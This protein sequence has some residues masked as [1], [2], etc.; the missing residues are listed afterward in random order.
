MTTAESSDRLATALAAA[1]I[2]RERCGRARTE[3]LSRGEGRLYRWVLTEFAERGRPDGAALRAKAAELGLDP[4][5][6]VEALAREDLL[7]LDQEGEVAVAYPFSGRPTRHRVRFSE[8]NEVF[9]MCALDALGMAAMLDRP[10][11]VRST[12]PATQDPIVALVAADG[13]VEWQPEEA[14]VL[15]GA[16][17]SGPS[18]QGCC[19]V[20]NFFSSRASAERY[21][22]EQPDIQGQ[23]ISV[24]E[25]VAAG[26]AIFGQALAS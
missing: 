2:S 16:R 1:G 23:L 21:L 9:A 12:D 24:P 15:A 6:A 10:I 14:V 17:C 13:R 19:A 7:H 5:S 4:A 25:A 3:R 8:G 22:G 20:V 11:E 18:Y 26:A